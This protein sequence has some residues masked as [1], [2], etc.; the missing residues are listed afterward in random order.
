MKRPQ[1]PCMW[2]RCPEPGVFYTGRTVGLEK[3]W[4]YACEVH[5]QVLAKENEEREG[6]WPRR[7][8]P[9]SSGSIWPQRVAALR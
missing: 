9:V 5:Q 3:K 8:T 4:G 7:R 6:V 2:P 1:G